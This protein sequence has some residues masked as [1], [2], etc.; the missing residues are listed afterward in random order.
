MSCLSPFGLLSL[1][2][3][4]R[5]SG[6]RLPARL[7]LRTAPDLVRPLVN[8]AALDGHTSAPVVQSRLSESERHGP[9]LGVVRI[10]GRSPLNRREAIPLNA[11]LVNRD[12]ET[13]HPPADA[14][15]DFV[16]DRAGRLRDVLRRDAERAVCSQQRHHVTLRGPRD[17]RHLD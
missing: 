12:V 6:G 16:G 7:R 10:A 13:R 9:P 1:S 8:A 15:G 3:C 11:P 5:Q 2:V 4:P 17:I 14:A